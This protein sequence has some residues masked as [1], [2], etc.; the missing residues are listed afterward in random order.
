MHLN[1]RPDQDWSKKERAKHRRYS[2]FQGDPFLQPL[3]QGIHATITHIQNLLNY[4]IFHTVILYTL[5]PP[6]VRARIAAKR[7]QN[8]W[9]VGAPET[10]ARKR[11]SLTLPKPTLR[12]LRMASRDSGDWLSRSRETPRVLGR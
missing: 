6:V 10:L 3:Q 4:E 7:T 1:P 11:R 12:F 9:R 8:A 5:A 2:A